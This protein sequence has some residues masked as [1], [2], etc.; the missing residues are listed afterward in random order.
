MDLSGMNISAKQ[1]SNRNPKNP[2]IKWQS[3]AIHEQEKREMEQRLK[4]HD[5]LETTLATHFNIT[6]RKYVKYKIPCLPLSW[7]VSLN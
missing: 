2:K 5:I 4:S 6:A 3:V 7:S 1:E